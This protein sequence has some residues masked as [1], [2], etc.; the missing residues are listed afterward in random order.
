MTGNITA[1]EN[2]E[3]FEHTHVL[4]SYI[5]ENENNSFLGGHLM[6]AVISYTG[7]FTINSVKNGVIRRMQDD[8]TGITVLKL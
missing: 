4:F 1:D 6:K 5:D 2:D 7:E 8:K 3:I